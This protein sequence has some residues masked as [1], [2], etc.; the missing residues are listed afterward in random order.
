MGIGY[1]EVNKID[2]HNLEIIKKV[3]AWKFE[4]IKAKGND[5]VII[6]LSFSE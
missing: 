2:C 5:K 3:K 6:P 4:T 1:Q